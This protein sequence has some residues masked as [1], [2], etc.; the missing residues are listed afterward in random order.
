MSQL[1]VSSAS[2]ETFTL[3]PTASLE[4][5]AA[6]KKKGRW[7]TPALEKEES[8]RLQNAIVKVVAQLWQ[9]RGEPFYKAL[10]REGAIFEFTK[11]GIFIK[12]EG[13]WKNLLEEPTISKK[14]KNEILK[15][16]SV[17]TNVIGK[18][19]GTKKK[20]AEK[21][22][23]EENAKS[24]S[25]Q[26]KIG[27]VVIEVKMAERGKTVQKKLES[28]YKEAETAL[29]SPMVGNIL[30]DVFS[31]I[32]VNLAFLISQAQRIKETI[33]QLLQKKQSGQMI[34]NQDIVAIKQLPEIHKTLCK[35]MHVCYQD[36]KFL[37]ENRAMFHK[38]ETEKSLL[39]EEEWKEVLSFVNFD[40]LTSPEEG[41]K[42]AKE[43]LEQIARQET[44][45]ASFFKLIEDVQTAFTGAV[46]NLEKFEQQVREA[47]RAILLKPEDALK[48]VRMSKEEISTLLDRVSQLSADK[49]KIAECLTLLKEGRIQE[50]IHLYF[51]WIRD[52]FP[53]YKKVC[54]E[55]L[56]QQKVAQGRTL[57][58]D[59]Q[60]I[61]P[62]LNPLTI[63]LSLLQKITGKEMNAQLKEI[64]PVVDESKWAED[65]AQIDTE[66]KGLE[67]D[68]SYPL[69]TE[70]LNDFHKRNLAVTQTLKTFIDKFQNVSDRQAFDEA[71][72]RHGIS[73]LESA[74]AFNHFP[75]VYQAFQS[76]NEEFQK[77]VDL[78]NKREL[79]EACDKFSEL[80]ISDYPK[81]VA[82]NRRTN[83]VISKLINPK[84]D[85]AFSAFASV[86]GIQNPSEMLLTFA[87]DWV[88]PFKDLFQSMKETTRE[89]ARPATI[90]QAHETIEREG[91]VISGRLPFEN[92]I[93]QNT[94]LSD[95]FT[96]VKK[97]PELESLMP[98]HQ[99]SLEDIGKFTESFN[100]LARIVQP[101]K[102][103]W[104]ALMAEEDP[105]K[106]RVLHFQLTEKAK[107]VDSERAKLYAEF[108]RWGGV[109][110]LQDSLNDAAQAIAK[111]GFMLNEDVAKRIQNGAHFI[112]QKMEEMTK[113]I[114]KIYLDLGLRKEWELNTI[115]NQLLGEPLS[116]DRELQT[117][118]EG[119]HWSKDAIKSLSGWYDRYM[120][121]AAILLQAKKALDV[122]PENILLQKEFKEVA[123]QQFQKLHDLVAQ[124][125]IL[126]T[127]KKLNEF[128]GIITTHIGRL[129]ERLEEIGEPKDR[130]AEE[131][132]TML[133]NFLSVT[134]SIN[135]DSNIKD[136][137]SELMEAS[138]AVQSPTSWDKDFL[139]ELTTLKSEE[140]KR[141]LGNELTLVD[142]QTIASLYQGYQKA[143]RKM[144]EMERKLERTPEDKVLQDSLVKECN[145]Q[146]DALKVLNER[147]Q[148]LK[149]D[150]KFT[151]LQR[152][153]DAWSKEHKTFKQIN[154]LDLFKQ[155]RDIVRDT[156][157]HYFFSA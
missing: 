7:Q 24:L 111:R 144:A 117:A 4:V 64:L 134:K 38:L 90:D 75:E 101:L 54:E 138:A 93:S 105:L 126:G 153:I 6:F 157:D 114:S 26:R 71:M 3:A 112:S 18:L 11:N 97:T 39:D 146:L 78:A 51:V 136:T 100:S 125:Q 84:V 65:L 25:L 58:F 137:D 142:V 62:R 50:G 148:K 124:N 46:A 56:I 28:F 21:R 130:E 73:S 10:S 92:L 135:F 27:D 140:W 2:G 44:H 1:F 116:N 106:M 113:G 89:E 102:E 151:G 59:E 147:Y 48:Q 22:E 81:L 34:G 96:L 17:I 104:E 67:R 115:E 19:S 103:G 108:R 61:I 31:A 132:R 109:K 77:V 20:F 36:Q 129:K 145:H 41:R 83:L 47:Q 154:I 121:E 13:A 143:L 141:S 55:L 12:E 152:A 72:Q 79:P 127:R 99:W 133:D 43:A 66:A 57:L 53:A 49:G 14:A 80:M 86:K 42:A 68:L 131:K 8:L 30:K 107:Q 35:A 37:E 120:K 128:R 95:F 110:H 32:R 85:A 149:I 29:V 23:A 139:S 87:Q 40:P 9:Q 15:V 60:H 74:F 16:L 69:L 94:L 33:T 119:A 82:A 98:Q 76:W 45:H 88:T 52:A 63:H 70:Q 123:H 122:D 155:K 118:L 91:A 150:G 5:T 156:Y